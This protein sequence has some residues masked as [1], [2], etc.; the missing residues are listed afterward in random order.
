MIPPPK[1]FVSKKL[2]WRTHGE[3]IRFPGT[4]IPSGAKYARSIRR[5]VKYSDTSA[6]LQD[7][8]IALDDSTLRVELNRNANI[9]DMNVSSV[10]ATMRDKGLGD[11]ATL[12]KNWGI[13]IEAAKR[14]RLLTTQRRIR[15]MIHPSLKNG[16]QQMTDNCG[17]TYFLSHFLLIQCTQQSSQDKGTRHRIRKSA[18]RPACALGRAWRCFRY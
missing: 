9:P 7:L 14:I 17:I 5:N 16:T 15:K 8:S 3:D 2:A 11:A 13:G 1:L 10:N 6:K 18:R 12:A 4:Y